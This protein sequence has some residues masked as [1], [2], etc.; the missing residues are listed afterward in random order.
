MLQG[1]G[2]QEQIELATKISGELSK[3]A[4]VYGALSGTKR[5]ITV[6]KSVWNGG[7][8]VG[9]QH[10]STL[11]S[12]TR[13]RRGV[14]RRKQRISKGN[15]RYAMHLDKFSEKVEQVGSPKGAQ[16]MKKPSEEGIEENA[17]HFKK[18]MMEEI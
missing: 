11:K 3:K 16:Q 2:K 4:R 7:M 1:K 8:R 17:Q 6:S 15:L 10:C 13:D 9:W 14:E 18:A 12:H 5:N